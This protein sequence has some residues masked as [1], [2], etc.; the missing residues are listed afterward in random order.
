M[1]RVISSSLT[2]GACTLGVMSG[3]FQLTQYR[4]QWPP[5][6][7]VPPQ[8]RAVPQGRQQNL[9]VAQP[10]FEPPKKPTEVPKFV[11]INTNEKG[12]TNVQLARAPV[13]S[14]SLELLQ[15]LNQWMLWLGSNEETKAVI[16]SSA[17]PTVFSAGLEFSEVHNP[18]PD[19]IGVFWQGFQEMWRILNTFPK[20]IIAAITGNSPAAGCIIAMGCDYRVM[21]RGPKDNTNNRRLYH[22][23]LNEAKL[24]LV[25]PPWT[26]S[27]YAYLMGPRQAEQ[28][29][30]LGD[31]PV[32]DDAQK[33]G[34]IDE[35]AADEESTMKM[36]YQQAE[37]FLS[38]PPEARRVARDMV[39]CEHLRL[40][41][42]EDD[43]NYD[44]EFFTQYMQRPDV[45]K[46]LENYL[47]RLKSRSRK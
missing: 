17:I 30:Q 22:I 37:R 5:L 38:V 20:P 47:E 12:I 21:A 41:A 10:E 3:L 28:M 15:E 39:R 6:P 8:L 25:A 46:N 45:Q 26:V 44:T 9:N 19:R 40:L 27:S 2:R 42:T 36:A 33:L 16:I 4:F 32:A 43:R 29:L 24:G 13:N 18:K 34:L 35:V 31:T 1:R 23:G 7:G 11:K 14:L